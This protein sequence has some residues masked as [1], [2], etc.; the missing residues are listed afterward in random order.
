MELAKG[1]AFTFGAWDYSV[2]ALYF[3]A[4]LYI[5][6]KYSKS[7][8][9]IENNNK[10][11]FLLA[12]RKLTLPMFVT[13]LV[14][15]WYGNIM[16]VGEF[17]FNDGI[18][19]WV[20]FSF[21]Y[22]VAAFLFAIF[23]SHK[24]RDLGIATIPEQIEKSY[25]RAAGL[26]S[27]IIVLIITIPAVYVLLLGVIVQMFTGWD[28]SLAIIVSTILSFAYIIKGGFKAD[29]VTNTAQ[30]YLM[31]IGFAILLFF[32][33][34]SFGSPLEMIKHLPASHLSLKGN[35]DYQFIIVWFII[36]FQTFVDPGFH[37]RCAA[38]TKPSVARK[39]V[40]ISILCWM[41]F[42]F[43]TLT[44]ALYA[45]AYFPQIEQGI[46]SYPILSEAVLP[47]FFKGIFIVSVLAAVMSTLD[48]YAF[49]SGATI[50]NDI[51]KKFKRY[52]NDDSKYWTKIGMI[53]TGILSIF[54]AIA[55]PSAVQLIYKTASIAIPGLFYPMVIT[56]FNK[57]ELSKRNAIIIMLSSSFVSGIWTYLNIIQFR[58]DFI[59]DN[60]FVS[61]EPMIPGILLSLLFGLLLTKK[62][63]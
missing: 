29:V 37:Q 3:I 17:I 62:R 21:T 14:A 24:I 10:E 60:I 59:I 46:M 28:L 58:F 5:G 47:T 20:C 50:G 13:T 33:I 51:I 30:F 11:D 44:T 38:V 16:G 6:F 57:Y 52:E 36:A 34:Y 9:T 25:G 27:S 53:I 22:Y 43:M 32:S 19:G 7:D 23:I 55:L 61:I 4:I 40:L 63:K 2:I 48:S 35:Y 49:I 26:I 54:L 1:F 15:T 31:Y 45:K 41:I 8:K 42:D 12:G 39:G 18:V 56:Y